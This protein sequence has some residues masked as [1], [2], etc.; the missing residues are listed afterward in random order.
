MTYRRQTQADAADIAAADAETHA[1]GLR[2]LF[3]D[4]SRKAE[5]AEQQAQLLQRLVIEGCHTQYF[6]LFR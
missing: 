1:A 3:E 2:S 5:G 6:D 4:Y